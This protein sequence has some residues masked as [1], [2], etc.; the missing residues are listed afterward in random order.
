LDSLTSNILIGLALLIL[1]GLS[2][3]LQIFRARRSSL[4]HVVAILNNL[5][6]NIRLCENFS[7]HYGIGSLKADAWV[8]YRE[9]VSF[10]PQE[11]LNNLSKVFDVVAEI[12]A[13]IDAA[14]RF[15][16]DSYMAAIEI[17]KLKEPL[18]SC[19]EQLHEWVYANMNNPDYL[20]KKKSLFRR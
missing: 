15:K 2:I 17:D 1:L 5:K 19:H 8:K 10:L 4:G 7:Y 6:H 16:T 3:G 12:N 14:T 9:K 20:P 13:N 18:V 11:L